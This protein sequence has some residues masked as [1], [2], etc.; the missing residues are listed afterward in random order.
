[1]EGLGN[2]SCALACHPDPSLELALGIAVL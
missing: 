2:K 1:L